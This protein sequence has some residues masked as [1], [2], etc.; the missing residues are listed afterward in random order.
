ME[1]V[2]TI[3]GDRFTGGIVEKEHPVELGDALE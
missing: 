1:E 3:D 2:A